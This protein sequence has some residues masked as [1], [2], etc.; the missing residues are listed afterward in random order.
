MLTAFVVKIKS[1]VDREL[2]IPR[3]RVQHLYPQSQPSWLTAANFYV[4]LNSLS[5]CRLFKFCFWLRLLLSVWG[6]RFFAVF[7]FAF[8]IIM[9]N[10]SLIS[11]VILVSRYCFTLVYSI[12]IILECFC[13]MLQLSLL[14]T[15]YT[16]MSVNGMVTCLV[17]SLLIF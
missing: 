13:S 1:G 7:L 12:W 14:I 11:Y 2:A 15:E 16:C 6:I 5:I 3:L 9:W 17:L 8:I 4:Y 10:V